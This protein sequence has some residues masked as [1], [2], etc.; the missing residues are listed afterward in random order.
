MQYPEFVTHFVWKLWRLIPTRWSFNFKRGWMQS[1]AVVSCKDAACMRARCLV[2]QRGLCT[3]LH[4]EKRAQRRVAVD[5]NRICRYNSY[6][7]LYLNFQIS[8]CTNLIKFKFPAHLLMFWFREF[9]HYHRFVHSFSCLSSQLN[10][11]PVENVDK[12]DN[13]KK[14]TSKCK[15]QKHKIPIG[16][17]SNGNLQ[18]RKIIEEIL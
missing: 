16:K 18:H 5:M 12:D 2:Y 10:S 11:F 7:C 4:K 6:D 17:L 8:V 15:N 3:Y 9:C 13:A 1:M 14:M